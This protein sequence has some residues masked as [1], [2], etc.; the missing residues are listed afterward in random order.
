[1]N[2]LVINVGSTTLKYA[3]LNPH[4]G[5]RLC[6]GLID[7]IGQPGGDAPTHQQAAETALQQ[8]QHL[9]YGMIG[10]RIVHGPYGISFN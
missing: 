10:H 6:D 8:V 3:C 9:E 2:V 4:T 1:M 7:R 5:A